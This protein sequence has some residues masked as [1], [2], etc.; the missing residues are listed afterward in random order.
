L[1]RIPSS[2]ATW[3]QLTPG[4]LA[5]SSAPRLNST[6]NFLRFDMNTPIGRIGLLVSVREIGGE[7]G[8]TL[9]NFT[10]FAKF[11]SLGI[12]EAG[13]QN[14]VSGMVMQQCLAPKTFAKKLAVLSCDC[15]FDRS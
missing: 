1:S 5:C 11:R 4:W 7:P 9:A 13:G 14:E 10:E 8:D 3:A 12:K 6:L 15:F 2:R